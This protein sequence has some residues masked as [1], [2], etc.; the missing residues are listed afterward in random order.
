MTFVMASAFAPIPL[1]L[2]LYNKITKR[3]GLGIG[4]RY[5]LSVFSLGM[6]I[7]FLCTQLASVV[8]EGVLTAIAI[9]GAVVVSFAI[10]AFFSISYTVPSTLAR[11]EYET[12][13]KSVSSMYFAVQGLFEGIA[14]GV[15]TGIILVT[16]KANDVIQLLPIIVIITCI[17]AFAMSFTFPESIRK[18]GKESTAPEANDAVKP[19]TV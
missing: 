1:T 2:M 9:P 19:D 17:A 8:S 6:G 12:S 14:A 10:G 4:Y 3:Y 15:A 7:M 5:V 13:G 16:L 11:I 18:L